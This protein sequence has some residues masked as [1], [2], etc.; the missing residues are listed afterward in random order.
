MQKSWTIEN[1]AIKFE[2][3][4]AIIER[5]RA[6]N[7]V[8]V[9]E[10][11]LTHV[12]MVTPSEQSKT[13]GTNGTTGGGK[14]SMAINESAALEKSWRP[15]RTLHRP[16]SYK[17]LKKIKRKRNKSF[18]G[19]WSS[20]NHRRLEKLVQQPRGFFFFFFFFFF[21]SFFTFFFF[22]FFV[23]EQQPFLVSSD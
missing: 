19:N 7:S 12:A 11:V 22:L 8:A 14:K 20:R 1:I 15:H 10:L 2:N 9:I 4:T 23:N 5:I 18:G 17:N 21:F 16:N 3:Y 13:N 6:R